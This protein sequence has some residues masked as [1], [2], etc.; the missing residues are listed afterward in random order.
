MFG[1]TVVAKE[2]ILSGVPQ[3]NWTTVRMVIA[4]Q[5]PLFG[6]SRTVR[7][8]TTAP[9]WGPTTRFCPEGVAR[10]AS[11]TNSRRLSL[12]QR[13]RWHHECQPRT[14]VPFQE[15][16]DNPQGREWRPSMLPAVKS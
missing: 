14:Q 3:V 13:F 9:N 8:L 7:V 1:Q 15:T 16:S 12:K 6:S 10:P 2:V 11:S 5:V 4:L